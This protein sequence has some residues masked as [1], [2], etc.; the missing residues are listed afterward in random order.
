MEKFWELASKVQRFVTFNGNNFDIP[1]LIIRSGINRVKIPFEI[2]KYSQN[3]IDLE[4]RLK[5]NGKPFKLEMLCRVFGI[6]DPKDKGVTGAEVS[7]LFYQKKFQQIAD[8]VTRDAV[9]TAEL[10]QI[11]R[12]YLSGEI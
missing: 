9:A 8:Y 12:E 1:Y 4:D 7:N 3:F 10:Y 6:D 5:Q 2:K 11:W